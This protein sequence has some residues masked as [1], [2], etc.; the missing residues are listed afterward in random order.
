MKELL[1]AGLGGMLGS[2]L[3]Y[4]LGVAAARHFN[5]PFPIGTFFIN[6]L[7]CL[8]IGIIMALSE[9]TG[10]V[11]REYRILVGVGFCGGF[12]T[13]SAFAW[14]NLKLIQNGS[15]A[16]AATYILL[17]IIGGLLLTWGGY[18]FSKNIF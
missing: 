11:P 6:G 17:S 12:T 8:I 15:W 4:S 10:L 5:Q 16:V 18:Q 2:M 1:L 14:E 13:F 3:R 9:K 7:G